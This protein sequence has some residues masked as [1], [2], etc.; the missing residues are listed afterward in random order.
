M[1]YPLFASNPSPLVYLPVPPNVRDEN[2]LFQDHRGDAQDPADHYAQT[3]SSPVGNFVI[4]ICSFLGVSYV[5]ASLFF[6]L[7]GNIQV[8]RT[9]CSGMWEVFLSRIFVSIFLTSILLFDYYCY[10]SILFFLR[11]LSSYFFFFL[12]FLAFSVVQY[13]YYPGKLIGD[14]LNCKS[15]V[16]A[17][18]KQSPTGTN[19]LGPLAWVSLSLDSLLL[20][21]YCFCVVYKT[22]IFHVCFRKHDNNSGEASSE[23]T[24]QSPY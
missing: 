10:W 15:C 4:V 24:E 1:K 23:N 7:S 14:T 13:I 17:I 19:V 9:A 5:G 11:G 20:L 12:Y 18:M 16:A 2:K 8:L 6:L 21:F 22:E 3:P